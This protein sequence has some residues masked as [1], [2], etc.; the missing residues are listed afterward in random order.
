[1]NGIILLNKRIGTTSYEALY[2]LKKYFST[3]RVGHTGTLDKFASGLLIVLIGKYT[4]L[5][6]YITS[7]DKEY[8]AEIE[9]GIETDTLDPNGRVINTTNYIPSLGELNLGIKSFIGEIEQVPPRFSSVHVKGNRAY[10]LALSGESFEIQ[11]RKINVYNIE[12]LSYNVD[13]HI[14]KLKVNCSKGT[15]VRSLARDLACSLGSLA[16]VKNLERVKIGDFRLGN[17]CFDCDLDKNSLISLESLNLFGVIYIDDNMIISIKNGVYVDVVINLDEL[18]IFKS[19]NEEMLAVI[20]GI[21]LSKY[22]YV[23]IF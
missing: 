19:R 20:C 10:K 21:G 8:I 4:R 23:I 6:N 11:T 18:K 14:L 12:I 2:P 13:F 17:A 1:M 9:F 16:Y 5:S 22:K 3:S 7:L 15:Y